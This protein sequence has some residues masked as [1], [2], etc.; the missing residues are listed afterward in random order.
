MSF[1]LRFSDEQMEMLQYFYVEISDKE[2]AD[3]RNVT[4]V[5]TVWQASL[6]LHKK[7]RQARILLALCV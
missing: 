6:K 3:R 4:S 1:H 2:I 5:S 7:E